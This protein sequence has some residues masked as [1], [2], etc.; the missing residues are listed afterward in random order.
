MRALA[1][2]ALLI[3]AT[4][5]G[6]QP[7]AERLA[8]CLACHGADGQSATPDTPSLGGQPAF[9][10]LAQLVMFRERMRAVEPM[11]AMLQGLRDAELKAMAD[12]IAKLPPPPAAATAADPARAE[13]AQ[14]LITRNRCNICHQPNFA[15]IE[16]VPRL[17]GQREDY[18]LKSLRGYK[19]NSR[20]GYDTQMA[21]VVASLADADFADLA[22]YLARQK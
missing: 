11:T 2:A 22:H 8:P 16:N 21:D 12:A 14:A 5:A 3:A 15:G 1:I 4:C 7:L 10:L 19:D 13:R 18:L 9:Y 17:A 6:A 20:R